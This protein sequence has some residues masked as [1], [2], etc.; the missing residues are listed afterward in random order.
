MAVSSHRTARTVRPIQSSLTLYLP[1][2]LPHLAVRLYDCERA[3]GRNVSQWTYACFFAG[4]TSTRQHK[5]LSK[6]THLTGLTAHTFYASLTQLQRQGYL[7]P[8]HLDASVMQQDGGEENEVAWERRWGPRAAAQIGE[9]AV[10]RFITD[11]VAGCGRV[12]GSGSLG[13]SAGSGA[14]EEALRRGVMM[15]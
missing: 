8:A 7:D 1:C 14:G 11:F 4:C 10:A 15:R 6:F 3:S 5:S 13:N 9:V 2:F 12:S